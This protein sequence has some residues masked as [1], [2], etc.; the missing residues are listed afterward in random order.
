MKKL[1]QV[2][3]ALTFASSAALAQ[4]H[5]ADDD[6]RAFV[7]TVLSGS[8]GFQTTYASTIVANGKEYSSEHRISIVTQTGPTLC[9]FTI[10]SQLNNGNNRLDASS[11][12]F[13]LTRSSGDF[14]IQI[15]RTDEPWMRYNHDNRQAVGADV[16]FPFIVSH[17]AREAFFDDFFVFPSHN[18]NGESIID[19]FEEL[20]QECQK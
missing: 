10:S 14:F 18:A 7:R 15:R 2:C 3:I 9:K 8:F 12:E 13:D 17:S 1:L 16:D 11:T 20:S 5:H 19:A 4:E 6:Y